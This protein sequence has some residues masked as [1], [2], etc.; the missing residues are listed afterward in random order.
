MEEDEVNTKPDGS[1]TRNQ[2]VCDESTRVF[3]FVNA[4]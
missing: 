2:Q 4:N 3:L 1:F